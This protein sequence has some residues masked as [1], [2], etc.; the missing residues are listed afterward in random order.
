MRGLFVTRP[1]RSGE[2]IRALEYRA[3]RVI[4]VCPTPTRFRLP[5]SQ[6]RLRRASSLRS[7]Q[8]NAHRDHLN[9][10]Y[11]DQRGRQ[12]FHPRRIFLVRPT[13]RP[14][15]GHQQPEAVHDE[16]VNQRTE[17][18]SLRGIL[19]WEVIAHLLP[20]QRKPTN[21][22]AAA[23]ARM[24]KASQNRPARQP[25]PVATRRLISQRTLK[26][27]L[28]KAP[29]PSDDNRGVLTLNDCQHVQCGDAHPGT[30]LLSP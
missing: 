1:R 27:P 22:N 3:A 15:P 29:A 9:A 11:W 7:G 28:C 30:K 16:L 13:H 21:S 2:T 17:L 24:D 5:Y 10:P 14:G 19:L 18:S 8:L 4:A 25:A 12:S 26:K 20:F 6:S 23:S